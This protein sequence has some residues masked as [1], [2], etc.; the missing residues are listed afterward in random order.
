MPA[1]S[2][3]FCY[4]PEPLA[5]RLTNVTVYSSTALSNIQALPACNTTPKPTQATCSFP[6]SHP[7]ALYTLLYPVGPISS[8]WTSNA[9]TLFQS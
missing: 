8:R 6:S 1:A 5:R 4:Q 9:V 7:A 3:T 2:E